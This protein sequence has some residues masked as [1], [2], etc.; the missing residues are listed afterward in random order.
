[1][2]N[3]FSKEEAGAVTV[4]AWLKCQKTAEMKHSASTVSLDS[5]SEWWESKIND[6]ADWEEWEIIIMMT[7]WLCW[8]YV[9]LS[10]EKWKQSAGVIKQLYLL[11]S[12]LVYE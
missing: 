3:Q 6:Y 5:M 9:G 12:N 1:M 4:L 8:F 10:D 11:Q 2:S 7:L